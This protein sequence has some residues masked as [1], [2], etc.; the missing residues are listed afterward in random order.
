VVNPVNVYNDFSWRVGAQ[1]RPTTDLM[2]YATA[3]RGYKGPGLNYTISLTPAQFAFNNAV[4][5]A[6]IA[7]SYEVGM[8][9][10][11]FDRQLTLNVSAF[12]SPFTNFQVTA[13]IPTTPPTFTTVN[14][15]EL[16]AQGVELEFFTRPDALPGFTF[17]GSVV[18]NDTRY[19]D[20][21]NAP[22]FAGQP[23]A[24][25]P[26]SSPGVCAPLAVGSTANV[27]NV[28]GFRAVGA[29]EW[30]VNLTPRYEQEVGSGFRAFGQAHFQYNSAVQYGV[31]NSPIT[32]QKGYHTI[33]LTAG[34]GDADRR[35]TLTAYARNIEKNRFVSRIA[36][37]SPGIGQLVPYQA[38]R[39]FGVSLDLAF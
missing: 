4:I 34:F 20:F 39:T 17:D 32:V 26:T 30:Q 1:Y 14:A 15:G 24:P 22:C 6:E 5:E 10:Q 23:V 37:T 11:W 21:T 18:Y 19:E 12:H 33:D 36:F 28:S 27:Q 31:G 16:L 29:P 2:F 7:H 38:L 3:S 8:R 25:A 13:A 35:W 9:S